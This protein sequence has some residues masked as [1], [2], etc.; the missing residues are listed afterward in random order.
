MACYARAAAE[1]EAGLRQMEARTD[2]D[3]EFRARQI[4]GLTAA[5]KEDRS[6]QYASAYNAAYHHTRAGNLDKARTLLTVAANDPAL[7][8]N[9]AELRKIIDR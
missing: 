9:I 4:E 3:P 8:K 1:T 5:V 7:E 2:L 6:Q